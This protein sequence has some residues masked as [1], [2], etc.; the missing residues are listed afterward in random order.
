MT[1]PF[2]GGNDNTN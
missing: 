2:S 1:F